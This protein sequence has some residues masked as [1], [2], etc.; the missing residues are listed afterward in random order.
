[1]A[2]RPCLFVHGRKHFYEGKTEESE[3]LIRV[4][5][6]AGVARLLL[7]SAAGSLTPAHEPGELVVVEQVLDCQFRPPSRLVASA[8]APAEP[9]RP[10]A[11]GRRLELD[12]WLTECVK[13][14]AVSSGIPLAPATLSS[15][16]GPAYETRTEVYALQGA[17]A[18]VA[19]MS[20]A[21]EL[22]V[23][24]AIGIQVACVAVVTN[25]VTG[26]SSTRLS[27]ERVLEASRGA[28]ANLGHLI[29]AV[30]WACGC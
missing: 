20:V 17:G 21:P 30:A 14:A 11:V 3:T 12:A 9:S 5:R 29:T 19:S 6:S 10:G 26:V 2:S 28:A 24:N 27:H 22:A 7:T 1:V 13:G 23:A 25:R 15:W 18:S 8:H 16:P 4:L